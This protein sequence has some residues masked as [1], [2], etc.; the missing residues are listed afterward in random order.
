MYFNKLSGFLI[1]IFEICDNEMLYNKQRYKL[2]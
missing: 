2:N 1:H